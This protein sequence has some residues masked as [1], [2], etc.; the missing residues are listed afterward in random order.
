MILC[1]LALCS[2]GCATPQ[3]AGRV[4]AGAPPVGT[5]GQSAGKIDQGAVLPRAGRL[6]EVKVQDQGYQTIVSFLGDGPFRDYNFTRQGE[7]RFLLSLPGVAQ[8][9][10]PSLPTSPNLPDL[11]FSGITEGVQEG[12]QILGLLSSKL[13]RYEL[14]SSE[15]CLTLALFLI[16][17][18]LPT[19]ATDHHI[20]SSSAAPADRNMVRQAGP[21]TTSEGPQRPQKTKVPE[22]K[23]D[24]DPA[25]LI[26]K[27]Y[28]GKPISFD[29]LDV[30]IRNVLRLI[31][32][33][34]GMN[35]VIEPDVV[36]KVTLKVNQVPWDQ[37]LDLILVMNDLGK[38]QSGNVIRIAKQSKLQEEYNRQVEQI[39]ARQEFLEASKDIG[40]MR[41]EYLTVN[42]APVSEIAAKIGEVKGDK[43]KISIDERTNLIIYSDYPARIENA[44]QLL[45]RLD[46]PTAQVMIEARIV[47]M[48]DNF[49][50]NLGIT[51]GFNLT[52][53]SQSIE[54]YEIN[55][56]SS[57]GSILDFNLGT[58]IG[59]NM[60]QLDLELSALER[61][62]HSKV[63]AAPKVLTLNNVKAIIS[64]GTQ[65]PY[66]SITGLD[67]TSTIFKDAVVEL[68]VTPHITPDKKIRLEI[69]AK[70][71][72]PI[73]PSRINDQ[74][75]IST[76]KIKTELLVG[77]G[78]IIVIGGVIRDLQ[79]GGM[80]TTP[81]LGKIPIIGRLFKEESSGRRKE[82]LLIFI[83]PKIVEL[84]AAGYSR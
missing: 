46:K 68:Q 33:L 10:T 26:N 1:F 66:L 58:M 51:W 43:G 69:E 83:S 71:D 81:G 82:E 57:L 21:Q 38:E 48:F 70:Q 16:P 42:Y 73:A 35:I 79:E 13:D 80:T 24:E 54:G 41:T 61:T 78:N 3:T 14:K 76:R 7:N 67:V 29:F 44:R 59:G 28:T 37:V 17:D 23:P 52:D 27:T 50:R 55:Y 11:S 40:E 9:G 15:N 63:I 49:T 72:E 5:I 32:D 25:L 22:K 45:A 2:W 74:P 62:N 84:S 36:G 47:T 18:P 12:I 56:L 65:I 4:S 53:R 31:A 34:T 39:K 8:S 30:D 6:L 19:Q 64:Q 20:P 60:L 77:D 75:S